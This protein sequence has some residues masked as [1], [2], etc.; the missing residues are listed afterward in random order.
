[1]EQV[2]PIY[3]TEKASSS[4]LTKF[5]QTTYDSGNVKNAVT[6]RE[7]IGLFVERIISDPRTLNRYVFI[8]GQ[9]LTQN[10]IFAI[11]KEESGIDFQLTVTTAEELES[12][13]KSDNPDEH[14]HLRIAKAYMRSMWINGDNT[15]ENA[16]TEA[17]GNA[18]DARELYP[19]VEVRTVRDWAREFYKGS[20]SDL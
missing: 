20:N 6:A 3:D 15:I 4:I 7:D 9:E 12:D 18:L 5:I 11:A 17:Y 10:E 14:P 13:L 19:D 2:F 1:M 16:K 8:Y